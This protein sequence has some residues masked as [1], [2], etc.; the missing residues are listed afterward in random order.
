MG[1]AISIL[2][3]MTRRAWPAA[4]LAAAAIVSFGLRP[5]AAARPI[6]ITRDPMPADEERQRQERSFVI[7]A[8]APTPATR[9]AVQKLD[10]FLDSM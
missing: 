2:T 4:L 5:G 6:G 7:R 8:D 3:L 9:L 1:E 10:G